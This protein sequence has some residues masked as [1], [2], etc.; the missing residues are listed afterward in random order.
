[1]GAAVILKNRTVVTPETKDKKGIIYSTVPNPLTKSWMLELEVHIGNDKQTLRGGTGLGLFYL[2][3]IDK[4]SHKESIFGYSSQF[5]GIGIYL[6][7]IL[8]SDT[9]RS[10]GTK[11]ILNAIQGFY[12]F[13]DRSINI[14]SEKQHIC[15]KR[16][17]NLPPG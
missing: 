12:N 15:Y 14:F 16:F 4:V 13:G 7:S 10:S 5:E 6:N 8:R 9:P 11:D 17:R 2:R 1:M 3:S